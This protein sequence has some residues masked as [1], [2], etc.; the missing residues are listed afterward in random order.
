MSKNE[1]K[2]ISW[3]WITITIIVLASVFGMIAALYQ[4]SPI[5][6]TPSKKIIINYKY[7]TMDSVGSWEADAGTTLLIF[8]MTIE[9]HGYDRFYVNPL[10]FEAVV[11]NVVYSHSIITYFLDDVGYIPMQQVYVLDGGKL[12]CAISFEIPKNYQSVSLGL[13]WTTGYN[14]EWVSA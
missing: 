5:G 1:K 3:K 7:T 2:S 10:D 14:I 9:N 6:P 11:D 4:A 8:N 12:V 13:K